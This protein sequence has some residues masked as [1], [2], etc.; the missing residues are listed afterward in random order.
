MD[1]VDSPSGVKTL[2]D[3]MVMWLDIRTDS[4]GMRSPGHPWPHVTYYFLTQNEL[5]PRATCLS[6][7]CSA[8]CF[9]FSLHLSYRFDMFSSFTILGCLPKS[10][11]SR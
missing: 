4:V 1:V 2:K 3:G 9:I 8:L 11:I 10:P 7:F 6:I 5:S